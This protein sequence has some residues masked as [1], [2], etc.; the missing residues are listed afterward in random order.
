MTDAD[1]AL[2][3]TRRQHNRAVLTQIVLPLLAGVVLIAIL[4]A[5]VVVLPRVAQ[6]SL[7]ADLTLTLFILC[8]LAICFLPFSLGLTALAI[9]SGRM[10]RSTSTPLRRVEAFSL[11]MRGQ[12]AVLGD[13]LSRWSIR[14]NAGLKPLTDWLDRAFDPPS[15]PPDHETK[16]EKH[17]QQ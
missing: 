8:P 1:A 3:Q 10:H 15:R 13:K 7:V 14:F 2:A 11:S 17:D 4:M 9:V 12:A 5:M 6:V 16:E